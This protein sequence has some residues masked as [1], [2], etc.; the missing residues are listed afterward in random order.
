MTLLDAQPEKPRSPWI[1]RI[2]IAVLLLAA[3]GLFLR[4][5]FRYYGEKKAVRQFMEALVGGDYGRAYEIWQPTPSY[6]YQ[7]F[8]QDW[9]EISPW[10]KIRSYEI[11]GVTEKLQDLL[12]PGT[13]GT[14][15]RILERGEGNSSGVVIL[16]RINGIREPER[17]WVEKKTK[18]LSFPP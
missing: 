17:I 14:N 15:P 5:Q 10:G 16:V 8:L 2:L 18:S 6:S 7:N 1:K 11:V 4:W 12:L 3:L 9:G 13:G